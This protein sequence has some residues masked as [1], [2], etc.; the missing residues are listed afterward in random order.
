VRAPPEASGSLSG[1]AVLAPLDDFVRLQFVR[2]YGFGSW[3]ISREGFVT[4]GFSHVAIRLDSG[5]LLDSRSDHVAGEPPGVRERYNHY[6]AWKYTEVVRIPVN[7]AGKARALKWAGGMIGHQYD[8][9]AIWGFLVGI[10]DHTRG[11]FI[12]SAFATDYL[13]HTG[14]LA[15]PPV[16]PSQI[17]PDVLNV[18]AL[19]ACKGSIERRT[20]PTRARQVANGA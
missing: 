17:S 4:R 20:G 15:K 6:E 19:T 7:S 9:A 12:C 3:M 1:G 18:M 2:G 16:P 10:R 14:A 11:A 8:E 5:N 13:V